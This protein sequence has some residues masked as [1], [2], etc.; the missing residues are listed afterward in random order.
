[1][2]DNPFAPPL[3][4]SD[5]QPTAEAKKPAS[6]FTLV[7]LLVVIA[8]IGVLVGLF[9]PAVR[10][11]RGPAR[12]MSCSNNLKQIGLALLNYENDHG[13]LPPAYTTDAEGRPLH[14][15]RSLILPY[16]EQ[17]ALY[18][19]IDFSKPW[20]AP[21]NQPVRDQVAAIPT[22]S[23]PGLSGQNY[24]S[25]HTTYLAVIDEKTGLHPTKERKLQDMSE[26]LSEVLL[27][28]DA[29][30]SRKVHWMSPEDIS[31]FE[32]VRID[33]KVDLPQ[34]NVI[35]CVYGDGK[36]EVWKPKP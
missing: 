27:V 18:N 21:E 4:D 12:R 35:Q 29:P 5:D 20:D 22:Y 7:E 32:F 17:Q 25:G 9:L 34:H 13:C 11:A 33:T 10:S 28:V 8:I 24:V 1:M 36:V 23:C 15:W 6:R 14:S 26:D 16:I 30:A 2:S 19:L 31:L 3:T